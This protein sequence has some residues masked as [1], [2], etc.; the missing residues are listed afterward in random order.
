MA[1]TFNTSFFS[2]KIKA[3]K[4]LSAI[5]IIIHHN[6][7]WL[8]WNNFQKAFSMGASSTNF[9][10]C[11]KVL[12]SI[13]SW[14]F[15]WTHFRYSGGLI[16]SQLDDDLNIP[17]TKRT[18]WDQSKIHF[19]RLERY[20]ISNVFSTVWHFPN[21]WLTSLRKEQ[22]E[23]KCKCHRLTLIVCW[24]SQPDRFPLKTF[25]SVFARLWFFD[26]MAVVECSVWHLRG[27]WGLRVRLAL[28]RST[29][30]SE[31]DSAQLWGGGAPPTPPPAAPFCHHRF[32]HL[33]LVAT[34]GWLI[35]TEIHINQ[36]PA[37]VLHRW[38][39]EISTILQLSTIQIIFTSA[40]QPRCNL[41]KPL[42]NLC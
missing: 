25:F 21:V 32:S 19:Q 13:R 6:H 12:T 31:E 40:I 18:S 11:T 38:R 41:P 17:E 26:V 30:Q 15:P 4:K 23:Q 24:D 22:N 10:K 28:L 14:G 36:N 27:L 16:F 5:I 37:S 8:V 39:L 9:P 29:G 7:L 35:S 42:F 3:E 2:V 34:P 1:S 33:A 20:Q